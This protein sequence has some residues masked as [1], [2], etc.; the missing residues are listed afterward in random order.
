MNN[1]SFTS[2][3]LLQS[4]DWTPSL[5]EAVALGAG[6]FLTAYALK[7]IFTS[8][9]NK[10]FNNPVPVSEA[11]PEAAPVLNNVKCQPVNT[12]FKWAYLNPLT[13]VAKIISTLFSLILTPY[14]V[15]FGEREKESKGEKE[16]W[17]N[18]LP[19]PIHYKE[20]NCKK[21]KARAWYSIAGF[22]ESRALDPRERASEARANMKGFLEE[23]GAE[24]F[25]EFLLA[26]GTASSLPGWSGVNVLNLP[27]KR[28]YSCGSF[29]MTSEEIR[30]QADSLKVSFDSSILS[31]SHLNK[32]LTN[33]SDSSED[34]SIARG[35]MVSSLVAATC[36]SKGNPITRE[37]D[38]P[39]YRIYTSNAPNL[40][41]SPWDRSQFLNENKTLKLEEYTQEMERIFLHYFEEAKANKDKVVVLC[42]FGMGAFMDA[43]LLPDGQKCFVEALRRATNRHERHFDKVI[44][45]DPNKG[46][47]SLLS[48]IPNM[49]VTNKSCLDVAHHGAK[50]GFKVALFNPGDGSGIPGQFW[51]QGHIALEEMFGLFTT[52]LVS[53]HPHCNPLIKDTSKYIDRKS[54]S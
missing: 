53:Q 36:D 31:A 2:S 5:G 47:T 22:L 14:Y 34:E 6:A 32:I 33:G 16:S 42:G 13:L 54:L 43:K 20:F 18:R 1:I 19:T 11:A 23:L 37:K 52:L 26:K 49:I 45:A 24:N 15:F 12:G 35:R 48:Q 9:V 10:S 8:I 39:L 3:L 38:L 40:A 51:L 27:E 29:F 50:K 46:L 41:Y 17:M 21:K 30:K 4:V 25:K 44:F 28:R 7:N